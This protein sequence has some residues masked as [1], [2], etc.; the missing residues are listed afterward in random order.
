MAG[1]R[2]A[3]QRHLHQAGAGA[4]ALQAALDGEGPEK[5]R[6]A[7][8]GDDV[9]EPDRADQAVAVAGDEGEARGRQPAF[10]QALGRLQHALAAHHPVEEGLAGGNVEGLFVG[11]VDHG[12]SPDWDFTCL[13]GRRR[14]SP[15]PL[16]EVGL[17]ANAVFAGNP[18][19][20]SDLS[21]EAL[22]PHPPRDLAIASATS[23]SGRGEGAG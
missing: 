15:L 6:L 3:A 12:R 19:E 23:P 13:F 8:A 16:G 10:A 1:K 22:I 7:A 18:G 2:G 4:P 14:P 9:P 17:H 11:D 21:G 20:G 5:E